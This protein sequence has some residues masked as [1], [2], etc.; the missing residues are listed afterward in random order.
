MR[1]EGQKDGGQEEEDEEDGMYGATAESR[2]SGSFKNVE[3]HGRM[4]W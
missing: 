4:R 1:E 2:G 3:D